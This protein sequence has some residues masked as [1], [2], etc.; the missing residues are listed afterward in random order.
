MAAPKV[1]WTPGAAPP[2]RSTPAPPGAFGFVFGAS[3]Q[4]TAAACRQAGL[5]WR[6]D[7]VARCTG[8]PSQDLPGAS[9]QLDFA[10][11][12]LSAVEL[13]I[14]PPDD[15]QG[16]AKALHDTEVALI[17]LFG[18]PEQRGFVVPDECKDAQR[19]LGCVADGKVSGTASWS[20][21][22]GRSAALSIAGSPP[23]PTLRVRV[24]PV[25]PKT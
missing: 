23:P 19:F 18:K 14:H 21:G 25:R 11:G 24:T 9:A 1:A 13:V 22:D 6:D 3:K 2:R 12:R 10:D 17:R 16:W 8:T 15:M 4:E 7:E 5:E 20:L